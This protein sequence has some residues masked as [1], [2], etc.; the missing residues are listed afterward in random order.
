MRMHGITEAMFRQAVPR[1]AK[2]ESMDIILNQSGVNYYNGW[3][4]SLIPT[5]VKVFECI[6]GSDLGCAGV[7]C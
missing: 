4:F 1:I 6:V 7:M 2:V 3:S 5:S